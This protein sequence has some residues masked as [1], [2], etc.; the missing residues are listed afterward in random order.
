MFNFKK[1]RSL[2]AVLLLLAMLVSTLALFSCKI[3]IGQPGK[4]PSKT[5][6][7]NTSSNVTDT[8]DPVPDPIDDNYRT[9]YEIYVRAFA[10]SDGNGVGDIRGIIETFDYLNDGDMNSGTDLGV[11]AIWLTPIFYGGSP[12]KYDAI[13]FYSIDPEFGTEEDLKELIALCD[14]NIHLF[15]YFSY[16]LLCNLWF[17]GYVCTKWI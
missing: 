4:T 7:K 6:D 9:L 3:V 2:L 12:H 15:R 11:Q 17:N 14:E 1:I 13:D 10:D 8:T 5:K 16:F